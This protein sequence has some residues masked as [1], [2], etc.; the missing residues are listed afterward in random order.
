VET[1]GEKIKKIRT[2]KKISQKQVSDICG[3]TPSAY[4]FIENGTTKSISIEVG[5]G[6]AQA[7]DVPFT[8]LFDI[9]TN[10]SEIEKLL[11][12]ITSYRENIDELTNDNILLK[13]QVETL[14]EIIVWYFIQNYMN[15]LSIFMKEE[16]QKPISGMEDGMSRLEKFNKRLKRYQDD[17]KHDIEMGYYTVNQ[18]ENILNLINRTAINKA[19]NLI[20]DVEKLQF[21]IPPEFEN[22]ES[23]DLKN[24]P[25]T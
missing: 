18:Y 25:E 5:K 10:P 23:S 11:T 19:I 17:F 8:E 21:W 14:Q 24:T 15:D 9:V 1:I 2:E 4:L 3:L 6:I 13:I 7:L 20:E 12:E 16:M 22:K